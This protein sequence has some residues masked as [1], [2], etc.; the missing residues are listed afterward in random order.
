M[1]ITEV[2]SIT[3]LSRLLNKS[4]PTVYKYVADFEG[5]RYEDIPLS[6][7]KLF[8]K[9]ESGESPTREIYEYC[10]RWFVG[11]LAHEKRVPQKKAK[12]KPVTVQEI[13]KLI[14]SGEKSLDLKKLKEYITKEIEKNG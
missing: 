6:V 8:H 9:I 4:R 10:D 3:E 1:K 5:G 14:K 12:E 7:R 2:V 13:F 11:S